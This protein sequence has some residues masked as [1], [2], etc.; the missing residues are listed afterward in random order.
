MCPSGPAPALCPAP[1]LLTFFTV[2]FFRLCLFLFLFRTAEENRHGDVMKTYLYLTG[3][4]NM[5]SVEVTIQN[6]I[7]SG[8]VSGGEKQQS[9]FFFAH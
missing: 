5:R 7:S 4:V 2:S 1:Q 8:M 6:L 9:R 3:R